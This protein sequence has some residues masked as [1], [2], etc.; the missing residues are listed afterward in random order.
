MYQIFQKY[1]P[2]RYRRIL[3]TNDWEY[4]VNVSINSHDCHM[5]IH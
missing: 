4:A 5:E 1:A 3:V 2:G